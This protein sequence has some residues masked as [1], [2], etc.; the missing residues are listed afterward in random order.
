MAQ[1]KARRAKRAASTDIAALERLAGRHPLAA[2]D[3]CVAQLTATADAGVL[4]VAEGLVERLRLQGK[5]AEAVRVAHAAGQRTAR[6]RLEAA[7]C[8]FSSGD[9]ALRDGCRR[10]SGRPTAAWR[11]TTRAFECPARKIWT[12]GWNG[13]PTPAPGKR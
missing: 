5:L 3:A 13:P 8:A 1:K 11:S 6:L 4:R 2:V 12:S 7:L 10:N 9:D